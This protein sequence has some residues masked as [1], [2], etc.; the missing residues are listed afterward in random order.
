MSFKFK[1]KP[2]DS[3]YFY[4]LSKGNKEIEKLEYIFSSSESIITYINNVP[5][6]NEFLIDSYQIL[7]K[8]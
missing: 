5:Q 7:M 1:I 4:Y 2:I 3:D 6:F 8:I